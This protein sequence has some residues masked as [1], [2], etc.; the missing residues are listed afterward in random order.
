MGGGL[1]S[2]LKQC[3]QLALGDSY[4]FDQLLFSHHLQPHKNV[5]FLPFFVFVA[6]QTHQELWMSVGR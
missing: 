3:R 2:L 6:G 5:F 1:K 4:Q